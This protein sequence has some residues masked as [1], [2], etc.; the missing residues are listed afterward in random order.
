MT[1]DFSAAHQLVIQRLDQMEVDMNE[2]GS[3]LPGFESR[4]KHHLV[5]ADHLTQEH[6]FGWV[7]FYNTEEFL[8]TKEHA[9]SLV[10]NAPLIVDR[11]DGCIYVTGTAKPVAF[12]ITEYKQGKRVRG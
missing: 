9:A 5:I 7:F 4:K 8:R 11:V 3:A 1:M 2:F 10:G 12:Y 6:D